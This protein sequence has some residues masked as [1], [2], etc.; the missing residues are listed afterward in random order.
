M[1]K[2]SLALCNTYSVPTLL[3]ATL[4][5]AMLACA[6]DAPWRGKPYDQWNDNDVERI[7]TDS[8]WTRTVAVPRTWSIYSANDGQQN[9]QLHGADRG[10]PSDS[11]RSDRA[12]SSP[13]VNF[14]VDWASSRPMRAAA[15]RRGILRG[16]QRGMDLEKHAKEP[17]AEYQII[18]QAQD[19]Q[20]FV[21]HD[22]KFFEENA[23]L[24][25]KKNKQKI[26]AGHVRYERDEKGGQVASV[27]FFFPK[28]TASGDP[29]ISSD[30]K[31]VTF[32]CK[33]EESQL[34]ATFEPQK[35]V[36][37]MGPTL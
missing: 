21:R 10:L 32:V 5:S 6:N 9:D 15:A 36:D 16:T 12:S 23:F 28:E 25:T 34:R 13:T 26:P 3:V 30:E 2:K 20:P 14:Y 33:V 4:L 1:S 31:S 22:E 37:N 18:V 29:V 11:N 24:L 27:I 17:Q 7:F 19:M 35:M 8:P